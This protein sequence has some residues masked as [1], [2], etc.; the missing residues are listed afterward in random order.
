MNTR[1]KAIVIAMNYHFSNLDTDTNEEIINLFALLDDWVALNPD[2]TIFNFPH[3]NVWNN[4]SEFTGNQFFYNIE[5]LISEIENN[6]P[7]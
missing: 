1:E 7:A 2:A 4:F 6:F 3:A 5:S